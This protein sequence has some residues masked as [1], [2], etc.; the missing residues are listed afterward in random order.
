MKMPKRKL[1]ESSLSRIL[2]HI[3]SDRSFGVLSAFR[4]GL[5][6]KENMERHADLKDKVRGMGYGFIEMR[7]GYKEEDGGF[8]NE[9]S[10][11]VPGIDKR[12]LVDLGSD[13]D[14]DSVI[15]KDKKSFELVGTNR[16]TG[17]GKVLMNFKGGGSRDSITLA[18][19]AIKDFF[20]SLV[21]GS[22]RGKKFLFQTEEFVLEEKEILGFNE[23]AYLNKKAR[24]FTI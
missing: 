6:K 19:D 13:L 4:G 23:V 2:Q 17:K 3:E 10:L 12:A 1:N 7:G 5:S 9:L 8:V 11:F 14:Q 15:Y 21:K 16:A 18:K 24:W 20:S 22:Q